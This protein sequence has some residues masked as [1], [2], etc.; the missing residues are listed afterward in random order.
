MIVEEIR[1]GGL[2]EL[3]NGHVSKVTGLTENGKV[4]FVRNPKNE[5]CAFNIKD[6]EPIPLTEEWFSKCG[7]N[8]E[9]SIIS[10]DLELDIYVCLNQGQQLTGI[11]LE[12]IKYVHQL[13]NLYFGITGEELTIKE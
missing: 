11:L 10:Y 9:D 8:E 1:V 7:C 6:F 2:F 4:W 13:Q 3:P 12:N 5:E